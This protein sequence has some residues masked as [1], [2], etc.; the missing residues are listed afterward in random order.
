MAWVYVVIAGLLEVGWAVG[1]KMSDGFS[2]PLI[3]IA[4]VIGMILSFVVLAQ[5][6]KT[7]PVGTAYAVWT[8]IGV[9]GTAVFGMIYLGEA[10][11]AVRVACLLM[12]FSGILGLRFFTA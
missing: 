7:L 3:S 5:G 2:R 1:L 6:M 11:D 8:G 10:H 4:T 9:V 12:I